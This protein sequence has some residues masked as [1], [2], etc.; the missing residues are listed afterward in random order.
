MALGCFHTVGERWN[1]S[2]QIQ[3]LQRCYCENYGS[4]AAACVMRRHYSIT[5]MRSLHAINGLLAVER[6]GNLL[7]GHH[8][9]LY[10]K[11]YKN[12][13]LLITVHICVFKVDKAGYV[14]TESY[15][16]HIS[17]A[18]ENSE[19]NEFAKKLIPNCVNEGNECAKGKSKI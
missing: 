10:F 3:P 12:Y 1:R 18:Y 2:L 13:Q 6:V 4:I 14:I 7:C 9:R 16:K 8:I 19:V 17:N 5:S 15:I 11:K